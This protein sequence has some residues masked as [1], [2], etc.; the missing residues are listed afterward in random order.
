MDK[1]IARLTERQAECLRLI[2]TRHTLAEIAAKLGIA[3]G[4]VKYHLTQAREILRCTSS[5]SAAR[6]LFEA[7][8]P[9]CPS[10]A[11]PRKPVPEGANRDDD[12]DVVA[13]G[14]SSSTGVVMDQ[15]SSYRA[16]P[17]DRGTH[18]PRWPFPVHDGERNSMRWYE[19]MA[20]A[21]A[22]AFLSIEAF[23]AI[24]RLLQ[25]WPGS[26]TPR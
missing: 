6:K 15:Q 4:T 16:G 10:W 11:G 26:P 12:L 23:N 2:Y 7:Q 3:E 9:D 17:R 8:P 20:W 21:I 14:E 5:A 22:I 25:A 24:N 19:Q 1:D 18:R 13:E